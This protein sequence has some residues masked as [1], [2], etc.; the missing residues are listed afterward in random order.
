MQLAAFLIWKTECFPGLETDKVST[1]HT[2]IR[3]FTESAVYVC[4]RERDRETERWRESQR[5]GKKEREEKQR[6]S[7]I[8]KS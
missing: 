3:D 6:E 1:L 7:E 2:F 5:E 8:R 4:V